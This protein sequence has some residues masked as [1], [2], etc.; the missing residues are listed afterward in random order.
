M[1]KKLHELK[2]EEW[3]MLSIGVLVFFVGVAY[4][5]WLGLDEAATEVEFL[6]SSLEICK[7]ADYGKF[8][9]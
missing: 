6:K 1:V 8:L 5:Y 9:Y 4:G 2:K 3:I 7:G